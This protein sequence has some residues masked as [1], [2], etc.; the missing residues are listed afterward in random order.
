MRTKR[1]LR[2]TCVSFA[3]NLRRVKPNVSQQQKFRCELILEAI[4][5][6]VERKGNS[7]CRIR[8]CL[9]TRE[10]VKVAKL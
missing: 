9:E 2:Q 5:A 10:T 6:F 7:F 4:V 3:S 1:D 8:K